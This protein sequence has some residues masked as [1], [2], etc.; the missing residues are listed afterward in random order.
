MACRQVSVALLVVAA[1]T[2][3]GS[4]QAPRGK[5]LQKPLVLASQGSFFVGGEKKMLTAPAGG[6][7]GPA[8]DITVNQMYVQYQVPP[9]GDRH[10]PVVM[11]HGCCLSSK[12][13]EFPQ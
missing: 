13:W 7:G 10:V 11:V 9:N 8:G 4:A 2:V 12:T 1:T 6:R 5:D 3:P